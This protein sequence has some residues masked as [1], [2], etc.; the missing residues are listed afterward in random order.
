MT[1]DT[2]APAEA[3]SREQLEA[4]FLPGDR[5]RVMSNR[6]DEEEDYTGHEGHVSAEASPDV[7]LSV[8][9]ILTADPGFGAVLFE[10]A[11]LELVTPG[12]TRTLFL[13]ALA[14]AEAA[15]AEVKRLRDQQEAVRLVGLKWSQQAAY[16][17]LAHSRQEGDAVVWGSN[18]DK[19][20]W[21]MF[22][23]CADE[24]RAALAGSP[25]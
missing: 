17:Q 11:E 4:L 14:R 25:S 2:P 8:S 18:L 15:E 13:A 21:Q 22:G 24:L 5:V 20:Q 19:V 1:I 12:A 9:V 16:L 10:P 3:L 6:Q 23:H 7:Q